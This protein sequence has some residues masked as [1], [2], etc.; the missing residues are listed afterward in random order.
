MICRIGE[1]CL[2]QRLELEPDNMC[3]YRY[4]LKRESIKESFN[5]KLKKVDYLQQK[6]YFY[7]KNV[8]HGMLR[9]N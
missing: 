3:I 4:S 8:G 5:K 1:F 6:Y 2:N 7:I 9:K